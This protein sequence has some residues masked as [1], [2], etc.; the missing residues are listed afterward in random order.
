MSGIF[1]NLLI[2]LCL[3][4]YLLSAQSPPNQNPPSVP[5]NQ[6]G[7]SQTKEKHLEQELQAKDLGKI[8]ATGTS[9]ID[10]A[11]KKYQSSAGK[12]STQMLESSPSGNGDIGSILRILP[13]VQFDN[14]QNRS[15]TPGEIDPARISISGGLHYQNSFQLDGMNMNNDLDP[16][17]SA[18]W[19]GGAPGRSQGL[20]VDTSLL[21]SITVLDSNVSAAY[22]GF[23]GGVVEANTRKPSK[24]IGA[25]ISYQFTQGNAD[26]KA[27][28]YDTLS[29]L[30]DKRYISIS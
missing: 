29:S 2:A 6:E 14:A 23:S 26:P 30:R 19:L 22:G 16:A 12:I 9:D 15:T 21:D 27:F 4:H 8:V 11:N 10:I 17:G 25:N 18:D 3:S 7:D 1:K 24:K 28:F 13:N 5:K 20:A